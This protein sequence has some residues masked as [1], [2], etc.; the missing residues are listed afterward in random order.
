MLPYRNEAA[1]ELIREHAQELAV[2]IVQAVQNSIPSTD[3]GPFLH[4]L[5]EVCTECGVL[6]MVDEVLTGFRFGYGGGQQY[7]GIEA[8][9][10]TY[11]KIIGGGLPIGAVAGPAGIMDLFS[12]PVH[13]QAIAVGGT[14]GG[15]P[16]V[17]RVGAAVLRHLRDHPEIYHTLAR[18]SE[19]MA[20]EINDFLK[21]QNIAAHLMQAEPMLHMIF[22]QEP[23]VSVWDFDQAEYPKGAAFYAALARRGVLVP[24]IH[25][26]FLSAAHTPEDVDIVIEEFKQT[27]LDCQKL[28]L[29]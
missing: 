21:E 9:L 28:G 24:G 29:F 11:G 14:F 20:R 13:K 23:V 16:M 5:R 7:F 12:F 27:F 1:F 4:Q 19:R 2:V 6:L 3:V 22:Q 10:V 25:L 15:N 17:M 18:Q 26:F 8:D